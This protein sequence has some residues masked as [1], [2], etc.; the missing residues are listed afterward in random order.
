MWNIIYTKKKHDIIWVRPN[1]CNSQKKDF[2]IFWAN[3]VLSVF[4]RAQNGAFRAFPRAKTRALDRA[5]LVLSLVHKI[6]LFGALLRDKNCAFWCS[7]S[8]PKSCFLVL[9]FVHCSP[10]SKHRAID[11]VFWCSPSCTKSCFLLLSLVPKI[12]PFGALPRAKNCALDRAFWCSP[13]CTKSYFCAL[14]RAQNRAFWCFPS[15]KK[16]CS[17][18]C[19]LVPLPRAQNRAFWCSPPWQKIVLFG[20]LPRAQ[21]RAFWCSP[22]SQK[23]CSRSCFLVLPFVH[24]IVLFV[25]SFVPQIVLFGAF[26]RA[27]NCAL[28]RARCYRY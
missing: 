8:C 22:S 23:P 26:P 6:V 21:N 24:K 20:A 3:V 25:L 7:P 19:F 16:S 11:R 15:C 5:F 28:D 13:S 10:L 17:R 1:S 14:L 27:K 9:F 12:V 4:L 2:F 18:P